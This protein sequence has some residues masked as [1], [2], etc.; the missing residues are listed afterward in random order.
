MSPM[1]TNEPRA[2]N[3]EVARRAGNWS[4]KIDIT[5]DVSIVVLTTLQDV[6]KM[7][8]VL[9]LSSAASTA[10]SILDVVQRT[11]SNKSGFKELAKD[12]CEVVYDIINAQK[13][14]SQNGDVPIDLVNHLE[15]LVNVL[16]SIEKFAIQGASRHLIVAVLCSSA[17]ARHIQDYQKKLYQALRVFG[18]QSNIILRNTVAHLAVNQVVIMDQ[19]GS[20]VRVLA[21][22]SYM[23]PL[24][25]LTDILRGAQNDISR[26]M[27][28]ET[29]FH[30]ENILSMDDYSVISTQI[31][32]RQDKKNLMEFVNQV[33]RAKS[34]SLSRSKLNDGD[35]RALRLLNIL[36]PRHDSYSIIRLVALLST[37]VFLVIGYFHAAQHFTPRNVIHGSYLVKAP[38][39]H[40]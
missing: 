31:T 5:L 34:L 28:L 25:I 36:S 35:R 22:P 8:P 30:L 20:I 6:A 3:L 15:Q 9:F 39:C 13:D 40:A 27:N 4:R 23:R 10:L 1:T 32:D 17:D 12:S 37:S 29:L 26:V 38:S 7:S 24:P 21:L 14:V 11:R 19:L 2:A 33:L 16:R 18:L